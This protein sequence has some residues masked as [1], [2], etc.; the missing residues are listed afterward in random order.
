MWY[1]WRK[2][3]SAYRILVYKFLGKMPLRR[4]LDPENESSMTLQ[5]VE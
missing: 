4:M 5:N 3:R 2:K 1:I